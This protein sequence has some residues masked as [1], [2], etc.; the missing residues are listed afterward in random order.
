[1]LFDRALSSLPSTLH[2]MSCRGDR[3]SFSDSFKSSHS[4][5]Q[6]LASPEEHCVVVLRELNVQ[7]LVLEILLLLQL[8]KKTPMLIEQ[9]L[10]KPR[11]QVAFSTSI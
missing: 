1:M 2:R 11:C 7:E 4:I 8:K 5:L 3:I 6:I 10:F 9:E